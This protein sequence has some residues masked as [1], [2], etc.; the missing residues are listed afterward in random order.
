[1]DK[2]KLLDQ[3]AGTIEKVTNGGKRYPSQDDNVEVIF[4]YFGQNRPSK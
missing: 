1:M 4:F 3:E 2:S